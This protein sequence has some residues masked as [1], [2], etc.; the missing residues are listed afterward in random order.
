MSELDPTS[1]RAKDR[2]ELIGFGLMSVV[3]GASFGVVATA[4]GLSSAKSMA[5]SAWA[6]G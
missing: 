6:V 2:W 1:N 5:M 4:N 3:F